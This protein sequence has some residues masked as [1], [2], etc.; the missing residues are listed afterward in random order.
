MRSALAI[1]FAR[2][3]YLVPYS[4]CVNKKIFFKKH[5][6]ALWQCSIRGTSAVSR[7]IHLFPKLN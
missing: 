3:L 6:S 2:Q 4:P 5:I 1:F 7:L